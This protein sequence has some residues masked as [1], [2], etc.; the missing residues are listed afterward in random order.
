MSTTSR[1]PHE[2]TGLSSATQYC[3]TVQAR[4]KSPNQ[5]A[6]AA[7]TAECATT[8]TLPDTTPPSPDP[9]SWATVP[10]A[11]GASS[12]AMVAT[13]ATDVSGVEYYFDCTAG[14]GQ[15]SGWQDS[16]TYTDT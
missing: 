11:T 10:Y 6:T 9:M 15:D 7:S 8:G 4:D 1:A 5:N 2:D 13:T 16:T 12:I 3:Y 14:G